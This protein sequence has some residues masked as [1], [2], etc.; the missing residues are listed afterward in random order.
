MLYAEL[1]KLFEREKNMYQGER[2]ENNL[3]TSN[4]PG[5]MA[6]Q[7]FSFWLSNLNIQPPNFTHFQLIYQSGEKGCE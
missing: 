4:N 1:D 6:D 2:T 5:K 3:F 7:I